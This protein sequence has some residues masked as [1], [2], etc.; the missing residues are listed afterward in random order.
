[1]T[2]EDLDLKTLYDYLKEGNYT[3]LPGNVKDAAYRISVDHK[4]ADLA[5]SIRNV[6]DY[7]VMDESMEDHTSLDLKDFTIATEEVAKYLKEDEFA[8]EQ[9]DFD[10]ALDP[11]K[12]E[13]LERIIIKYREQYGINTDLSEIKN[14]IIRYSNDLEAIDL[15]NDEPYNSFYHDCVS[16]YIGEKQITKTQNDITTNKTNKMSLI[17]KDD[18]PDSELNDDLN[19]RGYVNL[20]FTA[21]ILTAI[22]F[23]IL[24]KIF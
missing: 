1:M 15:E 22:A 5:N 3:Q 6:L 23:F 19:N 24:F 17:L 7:L 11:A 2:N 14:N 13:E 16:E 8:K 21:I 12:K 4:Y 18:V 10:N 9:Y 20:L